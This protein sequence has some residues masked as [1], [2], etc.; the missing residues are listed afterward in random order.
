MFLCFFSS[1]GNVIV[2]KQSLSLL[3]VIKVLKIMIKILNYCVTQYVKS[4]NHTRQ[5]PNFGGMWVF[6]FQTTPFLSDRCSYMVL[7]HCYKSTKKCKHKA[8]VFCNLATF[9]RAWSFPRE[10]KNSIILQTFQEFFIINSPS[11]FISLPGW[12]KWIFIV[13]KYSVFTIL[14]Q[15]FP[16]FRISSSWKEIKQWEQNFKF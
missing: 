13:K 15:K 2:I 5:T 1:L 6:Y 10:I 7:E 14:Y 4:W 11:I 3:N 9:I 8:F 12:I 16:K